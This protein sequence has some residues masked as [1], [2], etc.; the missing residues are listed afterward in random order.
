LA[1][2]YDQL[3]EERRR[4]ESLL[5]KTDDI[6][7]GVK[8][9]L[10]ELRAAGAPLSATASP[11]EGLRLPSRERRERSVVWRVEEK[12]KEETSQ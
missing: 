3:H 4:L 8:R 6:M 10:E 2:H 11:Q 5:A 7:R 12:E 1:A 9:G